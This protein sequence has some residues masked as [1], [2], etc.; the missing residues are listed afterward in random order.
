[1]A[2]G[3]LELVLKSVSR[4]LVFLVRYILAAGLELAARPTG[5]TFTIALHQREE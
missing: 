2:L 3:H 1:L 4:A 5:W